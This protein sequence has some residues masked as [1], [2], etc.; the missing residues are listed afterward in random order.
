[1]TPKNL[2]NYKMTGHQFHE[3]NKI[4]EWSLE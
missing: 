2:K 3:T 1:V 4:E